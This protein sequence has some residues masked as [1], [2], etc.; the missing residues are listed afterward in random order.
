MNDAVG[1][2]LLAAAGVPS[3]RLGVAIRRPETVGGAGDGAGEGALNSKLGPLVAALLPNMLDV[4]IEPFCV[5]SV[6]VGG[7]G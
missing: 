5:C 6:V 3:L 1:V 2:W 4:F 7:A